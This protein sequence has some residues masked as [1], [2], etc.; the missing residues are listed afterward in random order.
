[1][2]E[3][4]SMLNIGKEMTRKL[5][6][7]GINSAEEFIEEG[8]EQAFFKLKTAYPEVCLVHLYVLEGAIQNIEYNH[9]PEPRKRELKQFS[10][11]LKR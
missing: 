8:A 2:S 6:A 9:L 3:L 7:I 1:M 10:D 4:T 5:N 11:S